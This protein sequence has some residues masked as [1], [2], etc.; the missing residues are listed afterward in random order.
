MTQINTAN[1]LSELGAALEEF[2]SVRI[3]LP[4][5]F[6]GIGRVECF[7]VHFERYAK[8]LCKEMTHSYSYLRILPQF[9]RGEAQDVVSSFG[10]GSE[11]SYETVK[12]RVITVLN[13]KK[14][15]STI[16]FSVTAA[17][18]EARDVMVYTFLVACSQ[19]NIV[20]QLTVQ[21]A[22]VGELSLECVVR[23]GTLLESCEPFVVLQDKQE[24]L[25]P[26]IQNLYK[27]NTYV[28]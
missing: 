14:T 28:K 19:Q 5:E 3:P 12:E 4:G 27:I 26:V 11:A 25:L 24:T 21:L 16:A 23:T 2:H 15:V 7:F 8:D 6:M 9:L 13:E 18:A 17:S 20:M 10:Y 22:T 1:A